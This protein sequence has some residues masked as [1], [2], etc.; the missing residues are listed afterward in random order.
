MRL[1]RKR[2]GNTFRRRSNSSI[3]GGL[4]TP[5]KRPKSASA[6]KTNSENLP[7]NMKRILNPTR[8]RP[9]SAKVEDLKTEVEN[10]RGQLLKLK[11]VSYTHLTLPTKA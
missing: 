7:F 4:G 10:L 8:T 6:P 11:S 3:V 2:Y 1:T 9:S 5:R